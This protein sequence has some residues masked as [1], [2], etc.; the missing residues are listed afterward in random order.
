A[1]SLVNNSLSTHESFGG[2]YLRGVILSE[3]GRRDEAMQALL[4]A[5]S[6]RPQDEQL[7]LTLAVLYTSAGDLDKALQRYL[8]LMAANPREPV[9]AYKAG[10][11]YKLKKDLTKAEEMLK[12]ADVDGFRYRDQ[13]CLQL[14]DLALERKKYDEADDWFAKAV[15]INPSLKDAR[16]GSGASKLAK[17][18]DLASKAYAA[19]KYD[20]ALKEIDEARLADPMSPTP[21]LM[22]G[23]VLLA[24]QK[25]ED[26][27][28]PLKK[29]IQ[30]A[31]DNAEGYSLLGSAYHKLKK[32][33]DAVQVYR[34]G[35]K[36]A[37]ENA[38]LHNKLGM[39][40]RDREELRKAIDSFNHAVRL[41]PD[42]SAARMNLAFAFMDDKRFI[43]ARREFQ[44]LVEKDPKN[45]DAKKGLELIQILEILERGDRHFTAN[46]IDQAYAEYKKALEIGSKTAVV[47][48]ALARAEFARRNFDASEK[49]YKKAL[50][51]DPSN[52]AALQGL[53]RV[54]GATNR[55]KDEAQALA[56][57][58][59]LSGN[60]VAAGLAVGKLKED[61]GNLPQA[62]AHYVG[63]LKTNPDNDQVKRRLAAVYL[64]MALVENGKAKFKEA[65]A[66]LDK[67]EKV[68]PD[69]AGLEEAQKTIKEN[70]EQS[71]LV[72]VLKKAE[73][74]YTYGR[75]DQ[76]LPLY[77][78]VYEKWKRPLVLV[79]MAECK[80]ALGDEEKGI[81]LL[82]AGQSRTGDVEVSEAINSYL[83]KKGE[84]EKADQG[85]KEI[86]AQHEDA[87]FSLYKLG[88]I[89]LLKS[90]YGEALEYFNRSLIYRPD[91]YPTRIARGVAHYRKG[92]RDKARQEFEEASRI[93]EESPLARY[94]VGMILYN[95]NLLD[96]AETI[97]AD[98]I[99]KYPA[100]PDTHYHLSFIYYTRGKLDKA[101]DE[102]HACMKLES[103]SRCPM[104][105]AHVL[106]KRYETGKDPADLRKLRDTYQEILIRFPNAEEADESRKRLASLSPD[107]RIAVP[108]QGNLVSQVTPAVVNASL[109]TVTGSTL[110]AVDSRTKKSK[111]R[112]EL[113]APASALLVDQVVY[114]LTPGRVD[115][116]DAGS[117]MQLGGFAVDKNARRLI[118]SYGRLGVVSGG[119]LSVYDGAGRVTGTQRGTDKTSYAYSDG[120]FYR[121]DSSKGDMLL[122]RLSDKVEVDVQVIV[123][124]A[125]ALGFPEIL[126]K[127]DKL[128]LLFAERHLAVLDEKKAEIRGI[129]MAGGVALLTT[130]E[131]RIVVVG[132][133]WLR[134]I[135]SAGKVEKEVALPVGLLSRAAFSALSDKD[136][137]YV[138][139][140]Q[141]IR[142]I[143]ADGKEKWALPLGGDGKTQIVSVY[144]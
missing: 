114:V 32:Y 48:N 141:K 70:L 107:M 29:S 135:S 130:P 134:F 45:A 25:Y 96:Q 17:K 124:G 84:L 47:H 118:G 50:E 51:I 115:T 102:I 120:F 90:N 98:L 5:E 100:F 97:F 101:E 72:A 93:D 109:I 35:I 83:L 57:L 26:A 21:L 78:K 110:V 22:K 127:D 89:R 20:D 112:V 46:R 95:D 7:L 86:V 92:D 61:A 31:P 55:K 123:P 106:E 65:K 136:F 37:P 138:G 133:K 30:M 121:F 33:P 49:S 143:D 126:R 62:E 13:V 104:A 66:L 73:D 24:M 14:G 108:Y 42:Y 39:V 10:T 103:G 54:Y 27:L 111:Y 3:L 77:E 119:S 129:P 52:A 131:G 53:V 80:I 34:D 8:N 11:T 116:Y 43:D 139:T 144:Y 4:R 122:H 9:Y 71:D 67:A 137:L 63:L 2:H 23:T 140:D 64:K 36:R 76:A 79:R 18:L 94:N 74:A 56:K 60:E 75:F 19:G 91:F 142:Q 16:S 15:Q 1:L 88:V 69:L 59:K 41:Q 128:Y 99:K 6:I 68:S 105:L 44:A 12:K 40:L 125:G 82:R 132:Q 58:S 38:E 87:F 28:D 85:F 113:P 81:S 117:G